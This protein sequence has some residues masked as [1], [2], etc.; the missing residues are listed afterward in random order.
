MVH[1][2]QYPI[3]S[4]F[5]ISKITAPANKNTIPWFPIKKLIPNSMFQ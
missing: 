2:T 5:L 3:E 1:K 4:P